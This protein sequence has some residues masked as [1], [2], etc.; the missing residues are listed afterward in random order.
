MD[1]GTGQSFSQP[2][3]RRVPVARL[4]A[5][6][7]DRLQRLPMVAAVHHSAAQVLRVHRDG[8]LRNAY[9]RCYKTTL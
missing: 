7:Q 3:A 9:T 8:A 1:L 5:V 2:Q 4:V 6:Q